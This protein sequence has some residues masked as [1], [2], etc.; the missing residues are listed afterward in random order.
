M[1][2][3]DNIIIEAQ[4]CG[5]PVI[6]YPYALIF[7]VINKNK[8]GF[9]VQDIEQMEKLLKRLTRLSKKIVGVLLLIN[10]I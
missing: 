5:T 8:T 1:E 2:G 6:I 4:I 10:L 7:E 3:F 9:I